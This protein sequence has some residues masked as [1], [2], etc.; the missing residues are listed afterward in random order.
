MITGVDSRS[1]R[2]TQI[3]CTDYNITTSTQETSSS[4][5]MAARS[6]VMKSYWNRIYPT[7]KAVCK[8]KIKPAVA[9]V[10]VDEQKSWQC[11]GVY[12]YFVN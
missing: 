12:F 11:F 5:V 9:R 4:H 8:N 3:A 10:Y 7:Q 2:V 1:G 6:M